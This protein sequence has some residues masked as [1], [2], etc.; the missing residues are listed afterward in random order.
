MRGNMELPGLGVLPFDGAAAAEYG[1]V[2][3]LLE[4][5]GAV[6]PEPDLRI[7]AI[8]LAK[9]AMLATGNLRHYSRTPDLACEDRL[10]GCR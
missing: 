4:K 1:R 10:S 7:A 3:A 9:G 6:L 8:C 5:R 2:R